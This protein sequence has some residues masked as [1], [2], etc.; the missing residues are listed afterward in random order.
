MGCY[1][2]GAADLRGIVDD[3]PD[4]RLRRAYLRNPGVLNCCG[5]IRA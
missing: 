2:P 4:S 5:T 3:R 1:P